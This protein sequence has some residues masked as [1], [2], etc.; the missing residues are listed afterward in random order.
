MTRVVTVIGSAFLASTVSLWAAQTALR[1]PAR[2]PQRQ[3]PA[4]FTG[5][6]KPLPPKPS[7]LLVRFIQS[8]PIRIADTEKPETIPPALAALD[9]F[10]KEAPTEPLIRFMRAS[11][12]CETGAPPEQVLDDVLVA[13]RQLT[14]PEARELVPPKNLLVLKAKIEFRLGQYEDAM[15]DIDAAIRED[16]DSAS[17]LF[18]DGKVD[19]STEI[20][21]CAWT[22]ADFDALATR[23]SKDY[24]PELYRGLYIAQYLRYKND[25]DHEPVIDAYEKAAELNPASPLPHYYLGELHAFGSIGG[26]LSTRSAECIEDVAPKSEACLKLGE[27]RRQALRYFTRAIAVDPTFAPAHSSRAALLLRL[28]EYRQ[29]IRDYDRALTL[30]LDRETTRII[31]NDRALAKMQLGDYRGAILDL[32]RSI[33]MGCESTC[34]SYQNRAEAHLQAGN[35]TAA[36]ADVGASIKRILTSAIYLMNID[37]FRKLYPE[38]D[39]VADDVIAEK[40]RALFFP[41]LTYSDFAKQFLIEAKMEPTFVLSDLYLKRGDIYAK[42]GRTREADAEYDRVQRVFPT[43]YDIAFRTENGKRVRVAN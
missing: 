33:A 40:M 37:S 12:L 11:V 43:F 15:R 23:F 3:E 18:N 19:P 5:A 39:D 4:E 21:P 16:F 6:P 29:A 25:S 31:Y 42:M 9:A 13:A 30:K 38:Y 34:G 24:R 35:L 27:I 8:E 17:Q 10:V 20:K 28:K 22:A 2:T 14:T 36:L 26:L 32:D 7:P 41:E 1:P